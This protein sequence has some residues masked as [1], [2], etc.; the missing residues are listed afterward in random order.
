M[1]DY[2]A[3]ESYFAVNEYGAHTFHYMPSKEYKNKYF[4]RIEWKPIEIPKWKKTVH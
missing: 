2:L 3:G 4:H 1:L